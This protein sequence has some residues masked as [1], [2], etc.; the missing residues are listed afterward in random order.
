MKFSELKEYIK[1]LEKFCKNS[2][3]L[4]LVVKTNDPCIGPSSAVN[5]KAISCGIDW[6]KGRILIY[7]EK[8]LYE[9]CEK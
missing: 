2:D 7:P 9:E 5:V 3:D 8:N 4:Q 1:H 6:D